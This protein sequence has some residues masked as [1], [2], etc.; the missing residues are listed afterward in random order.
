MTTFSRM[1]P[2]VK[3]VTE[4]NFDAEVVVASRRVPVLVDFWAPWCGPCRTL[5]PLLDRLAEEHHGAFL[6]AKVNVDENPRLAAEFGIRSIPAVKA[7]T[8][9]EI[10]DEFVGAL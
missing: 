9:G 1:N 3:N 2:F 6:V 4:G 8:E 7:I 5:G 10:V